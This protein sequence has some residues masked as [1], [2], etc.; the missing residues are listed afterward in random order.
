M[1]YSKEVPGAA[2]NYLWSMRADRHEGFVGISQRHEDG[3]IER[4][5]LSPAQVRA[6]IRFARAEREEKS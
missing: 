1:T 5:L 3:R 2:G 4:V 6:L